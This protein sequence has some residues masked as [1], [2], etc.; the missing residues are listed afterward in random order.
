MNNKLKIVFCYAREDK[1]LQQELEKHLAPLIHGGKIEIWSDRRIDAGEDWENT[2]MNNLE[3]ADIILLLISSDFL[4]SNYCVS[5][6]LNLALDRKERGEISII[7]IILRHCDW[8]SY[9]QLK[10]LQVLPDA[11]KPVKSRDWH[12][13]EALANVTQGLSRIISKYQDKKVPIDN[14]SIEKSSQF[15][16]KLPTEKPSK[17]NLI[18]YVFASVS[19]VSLLAFFA[20]VY[21]SNRSCSIGQYKIDFASC[22]YYHKIKDVQSNISG[23]FKYGGSTS[24]IRLA[25]EIQNK[26]RNPDGK[27]SLVFV[28]IRQSELIPWSGEAIQRLIDRQLDVAF[29]S[30]DLTPSEIELS[31]K[32]GLILEAIPIAKDGLAFFVNPSNQTINSLSLDQIVNVYTGTIKNWNYFD[33]SNKSIIKAFSPDP[34]DNKRQPEYF[35]YKV[36]EG[37]KFTSDI[38]TGD[39]TYNIQRVGKEKDGIGFAST[40]IV[41]GQKTIRILAI[42][43][44]GGVFYPCDRYNINE[45]VIANSTYPLARELFVIIVRDGKD[46]E[47]A[48]ITLVNRVLSIEGQQDVKNA[49][50]I[51]IHY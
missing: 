9:S 4:N 6:E 28:N 16:P 12:P 43:K 1:N 45:E 20:F 3:I 41:C 11:G 27:L 50:Y 44:N 36:M 22:S 37:K 18:N 7:P 15:H 5:K 51:P 25:Q 31:R 38:E 46:R 17:F 10:S 29:S 48:G 33:P 26:I 2:L 8:K 30:R 42:K 35:Q 24:L 19:T 40:S 13:D 49:G 23:E 32:N 14:V 21:Y 34:I 39:P 47:K